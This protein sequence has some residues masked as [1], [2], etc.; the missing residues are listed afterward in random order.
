L[1]AQKFPRHKLADDGTQYGAG[2][3]IVTPSIIHGEFLALY[4]EMEKKGWVEEYEA[5]AAT[6]IVERDVDDRKRLNWR[7]SP[8]LVNQAMV[9][10]GKQQFIV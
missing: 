6:L 8:N 10:A 4:R 1:I 3:A 5:Y 9:F 7:D 2:Q